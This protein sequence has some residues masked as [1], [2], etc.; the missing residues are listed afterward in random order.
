MA[1]EKRLLLAGL[2]QLNQRYAGPGKGV[3]RVTVQMINGKPTYIMQGP[4]QNP[5]RG[6]P[7]VMT[8]ARGVEIPVIWAYRRFPLGS[9][10]P[11]PTN[12]DLNR[13]MWYGYSPAPRRDTVTVF[14]PSTDRIATQAK[15]PEA[16]VTDLQ[17]A[18]D[19][20]GP[21]GWWDLAQD[22]EGCLCCSFYMRP[23]TVLTFVVPQDRAL[24]IDGW[25]FFVYCNVPVGWQFNVR[26]T[27]D[28]DTLIDYDEVVVD[29]LNPDPA[30]RC[31]F[32]GS[33]EQVM[34]S[35]LRI[36]R[37]QT[38][39]V[40]ITPKGLAPFLST[41]LDSVCG[42]ICVLLHAHSTALL[43]NRDGAPRPKDVGRMRD[44][45]TGCGLLDQ[46][47]KEDVDQLE[48]WINA[49]TADTTQVPLDANNQVAGN[50]T[51]DVSLVSPAPIVPAKTDDSERQLA[52]NQEAANN[53][54]LTAIVAA[55]AI[56]S[57][58][59]DQDVGSSV[60]PDPL[61]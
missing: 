36:D 9:P 3:E 17:V 47:T 60:S 5:P 28:G 32:S 51:S 19:T 49:A 26:I 45:V 40:V 34:N 13:E 52:I 8:L 14:K 27:R 29:P 24:Y 23:V 41:P 48:M 35:Y 15:I 43:D 31:L 57:A 56:A 50:L 38:L 37:N 39:N 6:L 1:P 58:L 46:V 2:Q 22:L 61:G 20:T 53:G 30:K 55:A 54:L 10:V 42:N 12:A 59:G 33:I 11:A 4:T 18:V 21:L 16:A 25:S 44:D 7:G